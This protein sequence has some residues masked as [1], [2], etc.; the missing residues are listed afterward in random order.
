LACFVLCAS[1]NIV[2]LRR[3]FCSVGCVQLDVEH[4][5]PD[6]VTPENKWQRTIADINDP[7]NMSFGDVTYWVVEGMSVQ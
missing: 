6:Q 1:S 3:V 7:K 2:P 5:H 4:A